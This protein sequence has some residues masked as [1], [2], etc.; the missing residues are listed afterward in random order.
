MRLQ[1]ATGALQSHGDARLT[2]HRI[3]F[4]RAQLYVWA[5]RFCLVRSNVRAGGLCYLLSLSSFEWARRALSLSHSTTTRVFVRLAVRSIAPGLDRCAVA[6]RSPREPQCE[7][8]AKQGDG[9]SSPLKV[10]SGRS[11]LFGPLPYSFPS[12]SVKM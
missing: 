4:G 2:V 9:A 10:K 12:H 7:V 11:R 3:E 5:A 8:R 1:G 6:S